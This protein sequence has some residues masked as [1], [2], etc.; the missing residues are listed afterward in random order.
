[1][2]E[3]IETGAKG[4]SAGFPSEV[5]SHASGMKPM[6][7]RHR[8]SLARED[9]IQRMLSSGSGPL[10]LKFPIASRRLDNEDDGRQRVLNQRIQLGRS[11]V[12]DPKNLRPA[13]QSSQDVGFEIRNQ[14][15]RSFR[16]A[17]GIRMKHSSAVLHP[18][19]EPGSLENQLG[20]FLRSP[21]ITGQ[22]ELAFATRQMNEVAQ[23]AGGSF[24]AADS[25]VDSSM[26]FEL[27]PK[28]DN[29]IS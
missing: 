15:Q 1:M 28:L 4:R 18:S 17:F 9:N 2:Y 3:A 22:R 13:P 16:F 26:P 21:Q 6:S 7:D 29:E 12:R 19:R 20:H 11:G 27:A 24:G 10:N 14:G 5:F 23:S 25:T 8:L